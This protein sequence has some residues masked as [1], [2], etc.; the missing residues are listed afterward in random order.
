MHTSSLNCCSS[1]VLSSTS[2]ALYLSGCV[3]EYVNSCLITCFFFFPNKPSL[4]QYKGECLGAANHACRWEIKGVSGINI[5]A[6][7]DFLA[8]IATYLLLISSLC[9][10]VMHLVCSL[11]FVFQFVHLS[12]HFQISNEWTPMVGFSL[13]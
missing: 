6:L 5:P 3:S 7:S 11:F 9:F 13:Q 1:T 4:L 2:V 8:G 12:F 10:V